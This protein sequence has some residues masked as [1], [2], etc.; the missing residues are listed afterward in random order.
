[1]QPKHLPF[2]YPI[3]LLASTIPSHYLIDDEPDYDWY[4]EAST[5]ELD[6]FD[7]IPDWPAV[8][9]V[10]AGAFTATGLYDDLFT[11]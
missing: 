11:L 7:G 9:P 4:D 2:P 10:D 5:T 8:M 6:A 3:G 1:M